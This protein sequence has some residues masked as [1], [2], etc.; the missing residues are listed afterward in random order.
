MAVRPD[1]TTLADWEERATQAIAFLARYMAFL[2]AK[3]REKESLVTSVRLMDRLNV[4]KEIIG[5]Q[6]KSPAEKMY[7]MLR[8]SIIP[9]QMDE[10]EVTARTVEDVGRVNLMDDV[11][12]RVEDQPSLLAWLREM[13]LDDMIKENV[14]AQTLTAFVRRRL[15]EAGEK[16]VAAVLP[17]KEV[18]TITPISRAPITRK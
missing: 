2:D 13:E 9:E 10:G 18:M 7:D 6:V 15:K 16:K 1:P 12:C 5:S 17:P 3:V 8:F 14:N 4:F 11:Q